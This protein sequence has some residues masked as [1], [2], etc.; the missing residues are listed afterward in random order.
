MT[1]GPTGSNTGGNTGPTGSNTG[2]TGSNTGGNT[3]QNKLLSSENK[4]SFT[5]INNDVEKSVLELFDFPTNDIGAVNIPGK[6]HI[7]T[8]SVN[9]FSI[10]RNKAR[11]IRVGNIISNT[12]PKTTNFVESS[13]VKHVDLIKNNNPWHLIEIRVYDDRDRLVSGTATVSEIDYP[14]KASITNIGN[15][16][17]GQIY[18]E[19]NRI[20]KTDY[21]ENIQFGY[22]GNIPGGYLLQLELPYSHYTFSYTHNISRI[23]LYNRYRFKCPCVLWYIHNR[24][25]LS[26]AQY[27]HN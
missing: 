1:N 15:I 12:D 26:L 16:T 4:L 6:L 5:T 22:E 2:P 18:W 14:L 19:Q 25:K 13:Y 24:T 21:T 17:N 7:N 11:Y 23:E 3:G 8:F 10:S 20:R 27:S 9:E